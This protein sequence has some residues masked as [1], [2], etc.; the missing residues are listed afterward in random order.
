MKTSFHIAALLMLLPILQCTAQEGTTGLH[1]VEQQH[2][3]KQV[4]RKSRAIALPF[5]DDFSYN[6]TSPN[7]SLWQYSTVYINNTFGLNPPT[8][9]VAT[10]DALNGNGILYNTTNVN[11]AYTA[12]S[13]LSQTIN[14]GSLLPADSVYLSF[15]VQPQGLGFRPEA[16]DS[17]Q[18]YFLDA[19]G[20]WNLVWHRLGSA[21][22]DFSV[23]MVPVK[24]STYFHGDFQFLFV[25][26]ASP[27][28]NDDVWNIDYVRLDK[29]RNRGDSLITDLS[30]VAASPSI[31]S[32][33]TSMPY[34]HFY[35]YRSFEQD[36]QYTV[37]V[38]NLSNAVQAAG[39][40][41][42]IT[43]LITGQNVGADNESVF[44]PAK[45][46]D[47]AVYNNYPIS[48]TPLSPFNNVRF[49]HKYYYGAINGDARKQNDTFTAQYN[50]SNYFAYDDGSNEKAYYLFGL[51][52]F[53][54]SSA[55]AFHLNRP[56]TLRGLAIKFAQQVP[57]ALGKKFSIVL[58][59]S[60]GANTQAQQVLKQEDLFEVKYTQQRDTFTTYAFAEPFAL[61]SGLYYIG[62]TQLPNTNSD[63]I[64]FGLDAN[65]D[66]NSSHLFYNVNGTWQASST[67]GTVMLRP[68]VGNA[69]SPTSLGALQP[70]AC[71]VYPNPTTQI[72]HINGLLQRTSYAVYSQHGT[73]VKQGS[74]AKSIDVSS[75]PNGTYILRLFQAGGIQTLKF[76]KQ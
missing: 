68:I 6:S 61:D 39:V 32:E 46:V 7:P 21:V 14:L 18:L 23:A 5:I 22:Q 66:A 64:Y 44:P 65:T 16:N 33:Y 50:F 19:A 35:D 3:D 70:V 37:Y 58:Y 40:N 49:Q 25:N 56:D 42:T 43:E 17:L 27:N 55:L 24:S 12:D 10:F 29:N 62:T 59:K 51:P 57:S 63:T 1:F 26:K 48:F 8:F 9:G 76:V 13:L 4:L 31:L 75:L 28:S 38:N 53:S 72:L 67:A 45:S 20:D 2:T 60:L 71:S 54:V 36:T 34:W 41:N 52:N 15:Y 74:T 30:F 73:I 11:A 69:F 47:S